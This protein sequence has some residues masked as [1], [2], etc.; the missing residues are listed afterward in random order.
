MRAENKICLATIASVVLL[1]ASVL[2]FFPH[3]NE[4]GQKG[5]L[6][7]GISVAA[8][9]HVLSKNFTCHRIAACESQK[10]VHNPALP[11]REEMATDAAFPVA[12]FTS[13]S[14][15]I[16]ANLPPPKA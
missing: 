7:T 6:Q 5:K 9:A 2:I 10:A 8:E 12:D 1:F 4:V 13:S 16:E 15:T 14:I 11:L 3:V